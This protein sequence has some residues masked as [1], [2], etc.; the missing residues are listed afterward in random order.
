MRYL[1]V[2]KL[3]SKACKIN[4]LPSPPQGI[5]EKFGFFVFDAMSGEVISVIDTTNIYNSICIGNN[6]F[7]TALQFNK[8]PLRNPIV[9]D[10]IKFI[11]NNL[12]S[13]KLNILQLVDNE[14]TY[15]GCVSGIEDSWIDI[16]TTIRDN[17]INSIL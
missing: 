3:D 15:F 13:D 5:D 7:F 2:A 17:K 8:L 12:D 14:L 9:C 10:L 11:M 16:K 4:L 6:K 1:G